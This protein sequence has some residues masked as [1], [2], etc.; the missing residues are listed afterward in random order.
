MDF[1]IRN[2]K[3]HPKHRKMIEKICE[4]YNCNPDGM[5]SDR[6]GEFT[7]EE[8]PYIHS[9]YTRDMRN[10]VKKMT[11]ERHGIDIK[12][13]LNKKFTIAKRSKYGR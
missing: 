8:I 2:W 4:L 5:I 12:K 6:V 9:G 7:P 3:E 1:V 11:C 10:Q 13:N